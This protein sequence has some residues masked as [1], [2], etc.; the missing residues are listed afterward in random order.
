M[1]KPVVYRICVKGQL[2]EDWSEWFEGMAITHEPNGETTL[3]GPVRDQAA[4]FGILQ[5]MCSLNLSLIS[6]A[7]IEI[8]RS[9]ENIA[10]SVSS[11]TYEQLENNFVTWAHTQPDLRA[12]VVVGSRARH[13]HPADEWSD[14]DLILFTTSPA[15][16]AS[17][18]DW[19]AELGEVWLYVLNHTGH[20]DPEWL[21][22]FANG[23]KVD[24]VLAPIPPDSAPGLQQM[25]N[26][27]PYQFVFQRGVRA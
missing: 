23:L 26:D 15:W 27:S 24:F 22:L 21:V 4:L 2:A 1:S 19:L 9:T 25:L 5:K 8:T 13:H 14:L 20:G 10:K 11:L 7:S 6:V 3:I 16:Y 17:H 18:S 12:A